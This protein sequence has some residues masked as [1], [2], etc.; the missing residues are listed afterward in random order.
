MPGG[1]PAPRH[2]FRLAAT[3]E[4]LA[5]FDQ[6]L[7]GTGF[8]RILRFYLDLNAF[9]SLGHLAFKLIAKVLCILS[10]TVQ[11]THHL[12]CFNVRQS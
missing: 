2:Y 11:H 9:L 10:A 7:K 4:F 8:G 1:G 6:S 12:L 5:S 3:A